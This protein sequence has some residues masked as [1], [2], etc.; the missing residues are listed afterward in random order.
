MESH[1]PSYCGHSGREEY[2]THVTA[3]LRHLGA[4]F[5]V[6]SI[7]SRRRP[8]IK[9]AVVQL[10][11]LSAFT[12][13]GR[14][15]LALLASLGL[16]AVL[17]AP[18]APYRRR[19][20]VVSGVA[21]A[22]FVCALLGIAV[23]DSA[24]LLL[25][26]VIVLSSAASF[27][28]TALVV[29]PPSA[30]FLMLG[31][32][33]VNYMVYQH[34][35]PA[36]HVLIMTMVGGAVAVVGT[37][38]ELALQP[39]LPE[40]KAVRAAITSVDTYEESEPGEPARALQRKASAALHGAWTALDDAAPLFPRAPWARRRMRT[41]TALREDIASAEHKFNVRLGDAAAHYFTG[42]RLDTASSSGLIDRMVGSAGAS[43]GRPKARVLL[44]HALSW[45]SENLVTASRVAVATIIA[46][47]VTLALE[48]EHIYWSTAFAAVALHM[49]GARIIQS[50][51]AVNRLA[52]TILGIGLFTLVVWSS[53]TAW[54]LVV[55]LVSL[56]L[57]VEL[58]VAKQYAL[59]T[60]FITPLA[61]LISV[62]G[63][64]P[65]DPWPIMGER[66]LDTVIGVVAAFIAIWLFGRSMPAKVLRAQ[67]SRT[68]RSA[69]AFI[70]A[71]DAPGPRESL[72]TDL[73]LLDSVTGAVTTEE[74]G[75]DAVHNGREIAN[76]G[77]MLIG[78]RTLDAASWNDARI[79]KVRS[80][81]INASEEIGA[82]GRDM[83]TRIDALL[84]QLA[85]SI[86]ITER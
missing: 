58:F 14:F 18:D 43:S 82:G 1:F 60:L 48:G 21:L 24:P 25:V 44:S 22:L 57:L 85:A 77:Y 20:I 52:G 51:R 34:D 15:D 33:V 79:E 38:A 56:Q 64:I 49:G 80:L 16:F 32:G 63:Q 40:K 68:L 62:G 41:L 84:A 70:S 31:C 75:S 42:N 73:R 47:I 83:D 26:A 35:M 4:A 81:M 71:P 76:I 66:L 2:G 61:L 7:P 53:P 86:R 30:Y 67:T 72:Y 78:T 28:C 3:I 46:G 29:G 17:Y 27:A 10:I 39:H 23:G 12:A 13:F 5:S 37:M 59:A 9:V 19:L 65:D 69:A 11:T 36:G 6:N 45:P 8:A 54:V 74:G 50:Y 55:I